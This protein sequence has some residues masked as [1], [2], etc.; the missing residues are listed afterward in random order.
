MAIFG[1]SSYYGGSPRGGAAGIYGQ[2]YNSGQQT[3][4]DDSMT[5]QFKL[6]N[7]AVE[8]QAGDYGNIMQGYK[9]LLSKGP[10][11]A[12]SSAVSNLG[13]LATTGG[14]SSEDVASL[15]ARG[16]SPI[17]AAYSAAQRN[18]DRQKGLQGGYSPNY[19]AVQAK[20]A[21]EQSEQLAQGSTNV[22]AQIAQM[23]QQ[24]RLSA[25]PSYASAATQQDRSGQ[26][27]LQGM[28]SLYGTTPALS[29]LYGGQAMQ[30]A[31]LQNQIGQQNKQYGLDQISRLMQGL[32]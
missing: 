13:D 4:Q 19:G 27:A 6:Y 25:A 29:S 3:P 32:R 12:S 10:S 1:S 9:N 20:L 2:P 14:L 8:Q 21:R 15:R 5:S 11:S 23:R 22:E 30:G 31:Q 24:G 16:V 28:T 26:E 18:V 17:R 7:T